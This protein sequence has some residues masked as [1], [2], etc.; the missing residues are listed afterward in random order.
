MKIYT[1]ST[2]EKVNKNG[3]FPEYGDIRTP[4]FVPTFEEAENIVVNNHCDLF[5]YLYMYAVIEQL[6]DCFYPTT[7]DTYKRWYYKYNLDIGKYEPIDRSEVEVSGLQQIW[8]I[9]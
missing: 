8:S 5:E 7:D 2:F 4:I 1:I 6:T 3:Q 9:G